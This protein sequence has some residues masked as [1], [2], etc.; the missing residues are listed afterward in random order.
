[1]SDLNFRLS[2]LFQLWK[3]IDSDS[4]V[5]I[6]DTCKSDS[7]CLLPAD[8]QQ[9]LQRE[10][11]KISFLKHEINIGNAKIAHENQKFEVF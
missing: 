7:F 11:V 8:T 6:F 4:T 3:I 1:M 9:S 10:T 2:R 5:A